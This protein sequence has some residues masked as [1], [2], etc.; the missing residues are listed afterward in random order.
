[1]G[2]VAVVYDTGD[3]VG[4]ST[5]HNRHQIKLTKAHEGSGK[6]A[7]NDRETTF[8]H[9]LVHDW[10]GEA[11]KDSRHRT[12]ANIRD[13]MQRVRIPNCLEIEMTVET[14]EP[15]SKTEE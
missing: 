2:N 3:S 14:D 12:H 6:G 11:A 5:E 7:D 9:D 1:L 10:N 13:V 8:L 15:T 4:W